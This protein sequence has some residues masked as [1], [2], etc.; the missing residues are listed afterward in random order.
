LGNGWIIPIIN[1]VNNTEIEKI[2][3]EIEN[4]IIRRGRNRNTAGFKFR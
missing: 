3:G 4:G 1:I 2:L